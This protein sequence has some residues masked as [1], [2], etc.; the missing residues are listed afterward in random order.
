MRRGCVALRRRVL[1][2]CAGFAGRGESR[3]WRCRPRHLLRTRSTCVRKIAE[4]TEAE[5][6]QQGDPPQEVPSPQEGDTTP[7]GD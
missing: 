5:L 1:T 4:E 6:D 3:R 2:E 7:R